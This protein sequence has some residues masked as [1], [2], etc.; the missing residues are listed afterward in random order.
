MQHNQVVETANE[1]RLI[2]NIYKD[3]ITDSVLKQVDK[4][5]GMVSSHKISEDIEKIQAE[6]R[7]LNIGVIGRVKAGK[8]SLL[9]SLFF[10]GQSVLPKAATPMTAA[11]TTMTYG[12]KISAEVQLYSQKELDEIRGM[13]DQYEQKFKEEYNQFYEEES[14][15]QKVPAKR[16]ASDSLPVMDKQ[17]IEK[18]NIETKALRKAKY[19]LSEFLELE[20]A[21][22]Q[23]KDLKE[24]AYRPSDTDSKLL[25]ATSVEDLKEQLGEYVG[26]Q[27]QFTPYTKSV[28]LFLPF[29][30]LVG[31]KVIDTPGIND[32]I[33]SRE[34]RTN[35]LLMQCDVV[36][37]VAPSDKY[38]DTK[39]QQLVSRLTEREGL[40]HIYFV[41]SQ[42][43]RTLNAPEY[44]GELL[45]QCLPSLTSQLARHLEGEIDK[46]A[47]TSSD[48]S[49]VNALRGRDGNL[50]ERFVLVS[51]M[52][53]TISQ[54]LMYGES[55]EDDED[56]AKAS[57]EELFEAE[58]QRDPQGCLS[59][60]SG[61]EKVRGFIEQS[62]N[63]KADII[64]QRCSQVITQYSQILIGY[65]DKLT[66]AC[67]MRQQEIESTDLVAL[68]KNKSALEQ[69]KLKLENGLDGEYSLMI[70]E[71]ERTL[72]RVDKELTKVTHEL[73]DSA[74]DELQEESFQHPYD[75]GW[76][77]FKTTKYYTDTRQVINASKVSARL[78]SACKKYQLV[79]KDYFNEVLGGAKGFEKSMTSR[80]FG[81]FQSIYNSTEEVNVSI[82][83]VKKAI[84]N[85]V[86]AIPI[87]A[88]SFSVPIPG[89]LKESGKLSN[90]AAADFHADALEFVSTLE[91]KVGQEAS[92]YTRKVL[93]SLPKSF[94]TEFFDNIDKDI[95]R[96]KD[97]I[98]SK[99]FRLM[100]LNKCLDDLSKIKI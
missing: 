29:Q 77:I 11:L 28:N 7:L 63:A 81:E 24:A 31:I 58:F 89:S 65:K 75:S 13:S 23:A 35:Q 83:D 87:P 34:M 96:A 66:Q 51:A 72:H 97:D 61:I 16:N 55:F 18:K 47:S 5:S 68:Q 94:C 59:Q 45:S 67:K 27:G 32:P 91:I 19:K 82:E 93:Q 98:E 48:L 78:V 15:K 36:L 73:Q 9:N 86:S 53:D 26:S 52:A 10:K 84:R 70:R 62:R 39:D 74:N 40:Q 76:W 71:L 42:V 6:G 50:S 20:A 57:I 56:H 92:K 69:M 37:V 46:L 54:K 99:Q 33:V 60:L 88:S 43:D 25:T 44:A 100:A 1:L 30:D 79:A 49:T 95:E 22:M 12:E 14:K 8:S 3:H 64:A 38:F 21:H 2:S 4:D 85:A 90:R 41:A 80:L 17:D